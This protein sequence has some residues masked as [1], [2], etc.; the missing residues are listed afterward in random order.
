MFS[1]K[2]STAGVF[3]APFSVENGVK[4]HPGIDKKTP[5][6]NLQK[7]KPEVFFNLTQLQMLTR[8]LLYNLQRPVKTGTVKLL[9]NSR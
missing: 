3:A 7:V 9:E 2:R 8:D 6:T 1:I 5:T 4:H